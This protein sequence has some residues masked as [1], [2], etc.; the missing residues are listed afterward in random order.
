MSRVLICQGRWM[1]ARSRICDSKNSFT[2]FIFLLYW[3]P[4]LLNTMAVAHL[5]TEYNKHS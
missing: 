5:W 3:E 2:F 4:A 1:H